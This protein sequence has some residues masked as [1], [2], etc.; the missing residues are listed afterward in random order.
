LRYA[1]RDYS[2][3]G[4]YFVTI[5][6][7]QMV[8][9]FGEMISGEMHLSGIGHIASQMWYEIADHFP[10]IILDAFVVMPNHIHGII[11]INRFIGTPIVGAL[12]ATPLQPH[13]AKF[14]KNET[15]SSISPKRG[16]LSVVIRSYKSAVTKYA[17]KFD[18]GFSWQ[19]GFY[20][21]IICRTGQL[22]ASEN[23]FWIIHKT[24]TVMNDLIHQF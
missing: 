7:G 9:W 4:K 10:F 23:M 22:N 1:G 8:K 15:M 17:H 11:V 14:L 12:H 3:P 16:S 13:D 6:T 2:L 24:G 20:D 21:S 19:P 18:T 5:C